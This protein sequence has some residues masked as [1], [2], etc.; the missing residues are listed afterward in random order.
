MAFAK[1]PETHSAH[2]TEIT[3]R[4]SPPMRPISFLRVSVVI[5]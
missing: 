2:H 5:K 3:Y 4:L 1:P